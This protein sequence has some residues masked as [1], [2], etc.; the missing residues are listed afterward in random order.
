MEQDIWSPVNVPGFEIYY[1]STAGRL[2][3]KR[4][5]ACKNSFSEH[6]IKPI[7]CKKGYFKIILKYKGKK[8]H[9][10]FHRLVAL[11]FIPNPENKLTV[12]H[13][14]ADKSNNAVSN[15]EWATIQ[16]NN[17]HAVKNGLN[18][19]KKTLLNKD[20]I[21]YVMETLTSTNRQELA[22]MFCIT[23]KALENIII[24]ANKGKIPD[25]KRKKMQHRYKEIINV[26]TKEK[27]SSKML[28]EKIGLS[29]KEIARMLSGERT[30]KIP[31][32]YTGN[33][34]L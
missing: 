12:N 7:V 11:T 1:I 29:R 14:D 23:R 10:Y 32:E 26:L 25:G 34:V 24:R 8:C 15:L 3:C 9:T 22:D 17:A 2:K 19:A 20:D 28:S 5:I 13:I 33:Y 18:R 21:K 27:T 16:E 4:F 31:Y 30:N 6:Y